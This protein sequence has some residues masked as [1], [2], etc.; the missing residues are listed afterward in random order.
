MKPF[1]F[2]LVFLVA[3]TAARAD[4]DRYIIRFKQDSEATQA[5]AVVNALSAVG[6][7][8]IDRLPDDHSVVLRLRAEDVAGVVAR[9]DVAH[10]EVDS[11]VRAFLQTNDPLLSQQYSLQGQFSSNVTDAWDTTTGSDKALVAV[12]DTGASLDHPDLQDSI[13]TNPKEIAGN[14]KDDDKNGLVDD[15]HGYDFANKD[16]RP[17]DDNGHGTHV[18]G[19]IAAGGNNGTGIAGVAWS[20]KV[21]VVKALQSDGSGYT[22]DLAKSI[23]YVTTLKKKGAP[24]IA[25][26]LSLGGTSYSAALYRAV[27]RARN[28]DILVIAAAGNDGADNDSTGSYPANFK[29]DNVVSVAATDTA[30]QLASYSNFG[31]SSVHLAAPGSDIISTYPIDTGQGLYKILSGTSMASPHVA[32]IVSLISAAN[33]SLSALQVRSILLS[34]ITSV[35]A[36]QGAVITGGMT[37]ARAAV[38]TA[39][40]TAGLTRLVGVVKDTRKKLMSGVKMA[41]RSRAD[42]NFRRTT[43]T[44]TDGTYS[45]SQLPPG[46]YVV[47]A[48]K[49]GKQFRASTVSAA[50]AGV[51]RRNFTAR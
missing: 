45:F 35:A 42:S 22:S 28:Q 31:A 37:N 2:S 21:I 36:L 33:T 10:V 29:I 47:T 39:V 19:I 26:N 20:S 43:S 50:S 17:D 34:T 18:T 46:K 11:K 27:Q 23:D 49:A 51:I 3:T 25:I 24:V 9:A 16:S 14:H 4:D 48:R 5:D 7:Q 38:Q 12:I 13:W 15:V 1:V 32:G 40:A 30:G 41:I 44:A 8:E 6:L